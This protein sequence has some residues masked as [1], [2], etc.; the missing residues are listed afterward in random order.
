MK[1]KDSKERDIL[2]EEGYD[3]IHAYHIDGD[4]EKDVGYI[5]FQVTETSEK[6]GNSK[7]KSVAC[8]EQMHIKQH[9]QSSGIATQIIKYAK[10]IYEEVYFYPDT[11]CGGLISSHCDLIMAPYSQIHS[12]CS[13]FFCTF[14]DSQKERFSNVISSIFFIYD[15]KVD[16][17]SFHFS[18]ST[19]VKQ[20]YKAAA[21]NGSMFFC[22]K[23]KI[24]R[25][26]NLKI[27]RITAYKMVDC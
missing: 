12:F 15:E 16:V 3:T 22:K 27:K 26:F 6:Y 13:H 1:F 10:E 18:H 5:Q 21:E 25:N 9:Y 7:S 14:L 19:V 17:G 24:V 2:L 23:S 8:P 11:G 20:R 4:S